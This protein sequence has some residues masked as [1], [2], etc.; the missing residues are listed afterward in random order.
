MKLKLD[1]FVSAHPYNS[2]GKFTTC[3]WGDE[4]DGGGRLRKRMGFEIASQRGPATSCPKHAKR[5]P[6]TP[7]IKSADVSMGFE[8]ADVL[9]G[10]ARV[11]NYTALVRSIAQL[12]KL[13]AKSMHA[14]RELKRN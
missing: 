6:G 7:S 9:H 13:K 1:V 10:A 4:R 11:H 12:C 2:N 3:G 5:A 8:R 14:Q